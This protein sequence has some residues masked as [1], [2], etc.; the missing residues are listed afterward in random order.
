MTE[1]SVVGKILI[2]DMCLKYM[3]TLIIMLNI[4]REYNI[5]DQY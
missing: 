5:Y 3:P 2:F 1:G 4:M